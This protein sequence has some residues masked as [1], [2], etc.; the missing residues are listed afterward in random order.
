MAFLQS[1]MLWGVLAVG[2][3]VA[4][5]LIQRRK[6]MRVPFPAL[7]FILRSRKAVAR[8]FRVKQLLLLALRC[9]LVGAAAVAAA[10]PL[11]PGRDAAIGPSGGPAA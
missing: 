11:F 8:K 9:I 10:R 5:H 6:A 2:V 1:W 7:E 3:P 4:I